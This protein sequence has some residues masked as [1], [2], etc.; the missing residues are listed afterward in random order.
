MTLN[1]IRNAATAAITHVL[2][3]HKQA[4]TMNVGPR[5][6]TLSRAM[7]RPSFDPGAIMGPPKAKSNA[8]P[9]T[10]T[11]CLIKFENFIIS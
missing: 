5:R 6:T 1:Q 2:D 3:L 10:A 8:I 4:K 7:F 11:A 9:R